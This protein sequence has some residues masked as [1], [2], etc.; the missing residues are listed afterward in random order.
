M[1]PTQT[2]SAKGTKRTAYDYGAHPRQTLDLYMPDHGG[3]KLPLLVF[4]YGGSW[5]RG[6][7]RIYR[8]L[9]RA[10]AREGFGVAI[11]DY[12]LFPEVRYPAFNE[13]A[14][15][16]ISWLQ[17]NADMLGL[18]VDR[19][20][21][22]GHSAG[23]HIGAL[24]LL[25]PTYRHLPRPRR[26]VGLAGPYSMNLM[27]YEGVAPIFAGANDANDARPIKL[28]Q[29]AGPLPDVLLMHGERDR[30]VYVENTKNMATALQS[31]GTQVE[32]SLFS[33]LGHVDILAALMPAFRWRAPVWPK[34]VQFL[35]NENHHMPN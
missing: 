34:A 12:R 10:L 29:N 18:D 13:D 14:A 19:F 4:L 28:V 32:T 15:A 22:M 30:T 26:F 31:H 1:K 25:D 8:V 16:A 20:S 23:A 6:D 11:P 24:L 17:E 2:S 27:Q 5:K 9:G 7:R 35:K 21:L 3:K 33:N